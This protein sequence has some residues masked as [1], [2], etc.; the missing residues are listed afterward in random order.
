MICIVVSRS[1]LKIIGPEMLRVILYCSHM[2]LM[3]RLQ[4][5]VCIQLMFRK[6]EMGNQLALKGWRFKIEAPSTR[7]HPKSFTII[8]LCLAMDATEVFGGFLQ[9]E[10]GTQF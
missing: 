8:G 4:N 5:T 7:S 10:R 2:A 1:S 9:E 6:D 3:I